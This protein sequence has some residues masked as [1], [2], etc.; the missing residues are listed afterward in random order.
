MI[1]IIPIEMEIDGIRIKSP[2]IQ[3]M[4]HKAE[5]VWSKNTGRTGTARMQ[6]TII[7]IKQT[8]SLSWPDLCFEEAERIIELVSDPNKPF[9]IIKW[10]LPNGEIRQMECYFG[11]PSADEYVVR[12]GVWCVTNLKVD[13][14]ER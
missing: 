3:G 4:N 14:I 10:T 9:R 7:A 6:G 5:K 2:K 12:K 11:T 8:Q 13:A 1:P